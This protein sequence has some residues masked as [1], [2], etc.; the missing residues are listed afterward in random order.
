MGKGRTVIHCNTRLEHQVT[1]A[2]ALKQGLTGLN[3]TI[4]DSP[5]TSADL[6]VCMGPWFAYSRW[7]LANTLYIDRA[8]WGDPYCVSVHWLKAGEKRFTASS[9]RRGHPPLRPMK[10]GSMTI[11]LC[12]YGDRG[13]DHCD[14]VRRHPA[15]IEPTE[16]LEQALARHQRAIGG[17]S[18]ALVDAAIMGLEIHTDDLHSPV[19]PLVRGVP[20]EDWIVDLAVHNWSIDEIAAGEMWD[21]IGSDH[22]AN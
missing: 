6:H 11:Y 10:T 5:T 16:T 18:T 12:D 19:Y 20:R 8:Y 14:T 2:K 3:A 17:R 1:I 9:V 7:R 4:S 13:V 15:D 21:V 22:K